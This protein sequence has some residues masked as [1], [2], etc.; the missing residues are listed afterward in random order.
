MYKQT[1]INRQKEELSTFSDVPKVVA[2]DL[3][4]HGN[5]IKNAD[6]ECSEITHKE[7]LDARKIWKYYIS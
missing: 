2:G 6:N 5:A 3:W 4:I 1:G 7:M